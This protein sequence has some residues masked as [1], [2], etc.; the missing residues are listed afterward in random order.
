[1]NNQNKRALMAEEIWLNYFN[2]TLFENQIITEEERNR[3]KN[4]ITLR[5]DKKRKADR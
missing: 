5:C 4:Q 3:M 1:M 2:N